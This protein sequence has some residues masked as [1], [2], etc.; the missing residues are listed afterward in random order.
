MVIDFRKSGFFVRDGHLENKRV[1]REKRIEAVLLSLS[2]RS[3]EANEVGIDQ[4]DSFPYRQ[5]CPRLDQSR[6]D[7]PA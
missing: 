7:S 4:A 3:R 6:E 1:P 2:Q 5:S